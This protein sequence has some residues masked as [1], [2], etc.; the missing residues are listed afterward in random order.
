MNVLGLK[1]FV[2]DKKYR[3]LIYHGGAVVEEDRYRI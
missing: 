2:T 3:N 1:L